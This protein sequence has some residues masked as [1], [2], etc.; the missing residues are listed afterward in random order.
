MAE[1]ATRGSD[2]LKPLFHIGKRRGVDQKQARTDR[3]E[4][5][6]PLVDA[7]I[8]GDRIELRDRG[9]AVPRY[10]GFGLA[11]AGEHAIAAGA[12]GGNPGKSFS[13]SAN[14]PASASAEAA[15]NCAPTPQ[16]LIL[17]VFPAAPAGDA[18]H[19]HNHQN[20]DVQTVFVEQPLHPFATDFLIDFVKNIGQ[21]LVPGACRARLYIGSA[22][23]A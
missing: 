5:A 16:P 15:S 8:G 12:V 20:E 21:A 11:Q 3:R 6:E 17:I 22:A 9:G 13:A 23:V 4:V 7:H 18:G 19:E 1:G 10:R 2:W 14:L